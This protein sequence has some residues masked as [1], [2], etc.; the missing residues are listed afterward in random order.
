[1]GIYFDTLE[2]FEQAAVYTHALR[3]FA[4]EGRG[5]TAS[6]A[7]PQRLAYLAASTEAVAANPDAVKQVVA[8]H[9]RWI[10]LEGIDEQ[11]SFERVRHQI[12]MM[13]RYKELGGRSA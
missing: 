7:Q 6:Y 3:E 13:V 8:E 2:P 9:K 10:G 5:L 1:M 11:E 12:E 4:N